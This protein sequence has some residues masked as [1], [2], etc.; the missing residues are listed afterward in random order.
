MGIFF[1]CLGSV[2]GTGNTWRFPRV[3]AT[4]SEREGSLV[5]LMVWFIMLYLWSVPITL[6]EY[7]MGRFTRC[8]ILGSVCKF[9]GTKAFWLGGWYAAVVMFVSAY[10]C[11]VVGWCVYYTFLSVVVELPSDENEGLA[12]FSHLVRE[13]YWPVII[14][15]LCAGVCGICL[16]GGIRRIEKVNLVLVPL[17]LS[18]LLFTLAWS[19]T[20]EYAEVGIQFL[21]TPAWS[22][23]SKPG[24][25]IAAASQNAFDT[26]AGYGIL[27]TLASYFTQDKGAVRYGVLLPTMNN[28]VSLVCA[29]TIYSTVFATLIQASPTYTKSAILRII[30][31]TGPGSTGLTFIW[32]PVL[33]SKLGRTGRVLCFMFFLCLV[34]A[35]LS[36][37]ISNVQVYFLILLELGVSRRITVVICVL[38]I[39]CCGL[40]SSLSLEFLTNQDDVWGYALIVSG[41]M[42]AMLVI[43][44]GPMRYRRVVVNDFGTH[45]WNLPFLWVPLI[46]VAVPLIGL[47]L[48][49]W[50]I[51]DMIVFDSDWR[52]LNWNSLSSILLEWFALIL[53]LL[54][55]NGVVLWKRFNP[56]KDQVDE[57]IPPND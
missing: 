41:F 24:V 37:L 16:Y 15:V 1:S 38:W 55:V 3:V 33:F 40:P 48:V 14:H 5:F 22:S 4:C 25:W 23:F 20:R 56:Y 44:Y 19:L 28:A 46:T 35:G 17:L 21:F 42:F 13:T 26:A 39:I 43:L 8:S 12:A 7:S 53:V 9:L 51:H 36:T 54:L 52:E 2:V 50:W 10:Y 11:V 57:D 45:D 47:T 49:G 34:C 6:V 29:L 18:L 27:T 32:M 30:Q 31:S